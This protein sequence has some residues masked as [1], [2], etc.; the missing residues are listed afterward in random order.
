MSDEGRLYGVSPEM[1]PYRR[2]DDD[3]SSLYA[4]YTPTASVG[5][6]RPTRPP[7]GPAAT[8]TARKDAER[9]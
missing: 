9:A 7:A 3:G 5:E 2:V 1:A 6:R 8:S 4:G